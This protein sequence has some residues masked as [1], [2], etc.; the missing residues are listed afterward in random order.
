MSDEAD[1]GKDRLGPHGDEFYAALMAAH[2]G[3][4][5]EESAALNARLVL[6]LANR[7]A[8][9]RALKLVIEAAK[10]EIGQ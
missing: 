9:I 3:L 6:L 1:I 4:S 8:D 2:E 10:R 5:F 7:V